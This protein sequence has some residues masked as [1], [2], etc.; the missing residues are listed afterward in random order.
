MAQL[1]IEV[2]DDFIAKLADAVALRSLANAGMTPA[3][4]APQ[5]DAATRADDP[6]AGTGATTAPPQTAS[7]GAAAPNT[8]ALTGTTTISTPSG[9]QTVT[10]SPAGGP[11]CGHGRPAA[12][13]VGKNARSGKQWRQYRCALAAAPGDGW[14]DKC[15]FSQWA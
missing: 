7:Q 4:E 15:D 13:F 14:K 9:N 8:G 5:T 1:V 2:S 10:F 3:E 12:L 11:P 6:W